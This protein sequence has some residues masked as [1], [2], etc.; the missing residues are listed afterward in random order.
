M[1][2][3]DPTIV[4]CF[5]QPTGWV[6]LVEVSDDAVCVWGYIDMAQPL[7]PQLAAA[8]ARTL[9]EQGLPHHVCYF[10]PPEEH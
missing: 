6:G 10:N 2:P 5:P 8:I 1:S 4:A 9:T 7:S 3:S